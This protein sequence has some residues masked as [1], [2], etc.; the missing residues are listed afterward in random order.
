MTYL[1]Y[2]FSLPAIT[3]TLHHAKSGLQFGS[4]QLTN[5]EIDA[6]NCSSS[7]SLVQAWKGC[8]KR[9]RKFFNSNGLVRSLILMAIIAAF[10]GPGQC[11]AASLNFGLGTD[12]PNGRVHRVHFFYAKDG[13]KG[14]EMDASILN[15][16]KGRE[17]T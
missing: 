15:C 6:R 4:V 3:I 2:E 13:R 5:A 1:R 11:W 10:F 9:A 8:C 17:G 12:L 14:R 16:Q 7:P